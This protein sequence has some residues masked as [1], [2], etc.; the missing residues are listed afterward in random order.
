[1][2]DAEA[3]NFANVIRVEKLIHLESFGKLLSVFIRFKK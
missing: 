3:I 2:I 1:M